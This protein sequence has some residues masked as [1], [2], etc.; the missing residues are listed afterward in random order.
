MRFLL[1]AYDFPPIPSPQAL[2]WAYLTREL[3]K[4][5]HR[6]EVIAPDV[7]G[8]G[9]GGLPELPA[10]VIVR[11][12]FPG[13]LTRFLLGRGRKTAVAPPGSMATVSAVDETRGAAV[14]EALNWK[15]RLRRSL[16]S[17]FT[18]GSGLNWK[19]RLA[20][21]I[22]AAVS[23]R[24][25]PDYRAEWVEHAIAMLQVSVAEARPDVVVVSHEP[26]CSLP[27]GIA[28]ARQGLPLVVDLGD[29]VLAPYTPEKW[30]EAAFALERDACHA[31]M[32]VSVTTDAAAEVLQ[33]RHSLSDENIVV[34]RQGFDPDFRAD[35]ARSGVLFDSGMLEL[36]YTGSFYSFRSAHMLLD[37]VLSVPGV[38][39]SIATILAPDYLLEYV[40]RSQGRIRLLGFLPHTAAV[41]A[42]RQCD[43]LVNLANADPV[44]VPGKIFEY[45]GA[46]KPVMHLRGEHQDATGV[47]VSATRAGW[48]IAS[49]PGQIESALLEAIE[50]KA[51]GKLSMRAPRR[52]Q[53]AQYSWPSL[54]ARWLSDVEA[55]LDR[56]RRSADAIS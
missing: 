6:V 5:G 28:A 36:L 19:G 51:G 3:V 17:S 41:A 13:R 43:I 9:P 37:V 11:R 26:A 44:Q 49:T 40:E 54:A 38:R 32:M 30:K 56:R 42:Q 23:D 2:R 29:P 14:E 27:V 53:V 47:L 15:G 45:L 1:I 18:D 34:I 48:D 4:S 46:G 31:A 35:D 12:V 20:E 21:R 55:A 10:D 39:L 52:D 25:F 8:Y 50:C 24:V 33:E 22:K 16:E 7:P